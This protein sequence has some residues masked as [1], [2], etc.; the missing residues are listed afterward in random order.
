VTKERKT[1][2]ATIAALILALGVAVGQKQGW[3]WGASAQNPPPTPP[4]A[5]YAMLDAA[6]AGNVSA[7]LASY[8]GSMQASLEQ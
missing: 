1:H 2:I 4:D 6:R 7:Y 8:T 3:G 5:I